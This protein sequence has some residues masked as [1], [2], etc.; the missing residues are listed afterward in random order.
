MCLAVPAE[1]TELLD[2]EQATVNLGGVSKT[3]SVALIDDL[4][5]GDYVIVHTGYALNKIDADEAQKTLKL[6]EEMGYDLGNQ[7]A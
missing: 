7:E 1:V 4:N 2:D 5:I 6:F 3:I